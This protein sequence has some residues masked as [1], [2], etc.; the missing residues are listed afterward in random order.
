MAP[1]FPLL[2]QASTVIYYNVM[3]T[4]LRLWLS[5]GK[6]LGT[7]NTYIILTLVFIFVVTPIGLLK[8]LLGKDFLRDNPPGSLWIERKGKED[9]ERQF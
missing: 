4:F 1:G 3:R 2:K 6:A 7:V 9:L 8:R 5:F